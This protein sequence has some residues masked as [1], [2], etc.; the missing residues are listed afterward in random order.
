M[1][2][3]YC[4]GDGQ[5]RG[6]GGNTAH[7]ISSDEWF[8]HQTWEAKFLQRVMLSIT[9]F[10]GTHFG[11]KNAFVV[12]DQEDETREFDGLLGPSDFGLKQT[13]PWKK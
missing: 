7:G 2:E 5:P 12:E 6:I 1:G 8:S 3:Q 13:L 10:G 9:K 11:Q 4:G